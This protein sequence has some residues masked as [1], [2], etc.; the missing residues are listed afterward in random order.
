MTSL[1]GLQPLKLKSNTS[2]FCPEA[3][4]PRPP[5]APKCGVSPVLSGE[6]QEEMAAALTQSAAPYCDCQ[7]DRPRLPSRWPRMEMEGGG[8]ARFPSSHRLAAAPAVEG[9]SAIVS[10]GQVMAISPRPGFIECSLHV[11][12][13]HFFSRPEIWVVTHSATRSC[14]EH[15][16]IK[17]TVKQNF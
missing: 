4:T 3:V 1:K 11:C 7:K 14:N 10:T 13:T 5:T 15:P 8:G 2:R 6:G 16:S 17:S 12:T 9:L